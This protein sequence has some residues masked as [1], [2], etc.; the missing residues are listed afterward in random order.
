MIDFLHNANIL[1]DSYS[2]HKDSDEI[3]NKIALFLGNNYSCLHD[4]LANI[5]RNMNKGGTFSLNLK[6][7]SQQNIGTICQFSYNLHSIAFLE[8]YNYKRSP[9]YN[10]FVK[11][12]T[13][14]VAQNFFS[15]Q[16]LERFALM[17]I[18]EVIEKISYLHLTFS[19]LLNP[20]ITLANG[21]KFELDCLFQMNN[22]IYW[23]ECKTGDYQQHISK[24]SKFL[25]TLNLD[26]KRCFLLLADI[27]SYKAMDL[28]KIYSMCIIPFTEFRNKLIQ[29]IHTDLHIQDVSLNIILEH[30][31]D[32]SKSY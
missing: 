13:Y 15:G 20:K 2:E 18:R 4:I 16:W 28:S 25:R 32:D 14:S 11:T 26:D 17:V 3:I 29:Q 30:K 23:I 22:N 5:K 1:V 31:S 21:D 6:N 8:Q 27:T 7:I 10:L 12:S 24:Y 19:Y 9:H